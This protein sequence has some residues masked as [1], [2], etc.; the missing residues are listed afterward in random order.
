MNLKE[1]ID[2]YLNYVGNDAQMLEDEVKEKFYLLVLYLVKLERGFKGYCSNENCSCQTMFI[3]KKL[4]ED[5]KLIKFV[6]AYNIDIKDI[7]KGQVK[8]NE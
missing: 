8:T 7:L 4:L 3:I 6:N 5:K 1:I 2:L